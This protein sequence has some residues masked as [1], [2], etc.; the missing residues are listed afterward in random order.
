MFGLNLESVQIYEEHRGCQTVNGSGV[1]CAKVSP[2]VQ[3]SGP[4]H[5]ASPPITDSQ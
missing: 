5:R 3:S 1:E 4:V 2:V